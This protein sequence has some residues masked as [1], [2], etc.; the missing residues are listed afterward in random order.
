MTGRL[1]PIPVRLVGGPRDGQI[2]NLWPD[3]LGDTLELLCHADR[4]DDRG[5]WFHRY[6]RRPNGDYQFAGWGWLP[7]QHTEVGE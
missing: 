6:Q 3:T 5:L 7:G 2:E 4:V 1:F